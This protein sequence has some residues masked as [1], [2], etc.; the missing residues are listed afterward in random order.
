MKQELEGKKNDLE[1]IEYIKDAAKSMAGVQP[2]PHF[3]SEF[4]P[5]G[6]QHEELVVEKEIKDEEE[7]PD[8]DISVVNDLPNKVDQFLE[9]FLQNGVCKKYISLSMLTRFIWVGSWS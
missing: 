3:L 1:V 6:S 4:A 5:E 8:I 7:D 9:V 2:R